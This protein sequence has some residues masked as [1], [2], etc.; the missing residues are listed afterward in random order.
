MAATVNTPAPQNL[1]ELR[2]LLGLVNLYRKF[3][4]DVATIL[5]PLHQLL[6]KG[7]LWKR[8]REQQEALDKVKELLESPTFLSTL[9]GTSHCCWHVMLHRMV[10][11]LFFL[12]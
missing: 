9:T 6:Q 11:E 10:W 5:T 7:I 4:P 3:L 8:N 1:T 2:S 12:I